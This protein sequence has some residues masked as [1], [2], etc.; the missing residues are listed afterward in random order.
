MCKANAWGKLT[1]VRPTKLYMDYVNR[2]GAADASELFMRD[3]AVSQAKTKQLAEIAQ[4]EK[5][6]IAEVGENSAAVYVNIPFC[7]SRCLYCSFVTCIKQTP[8]IMD[9]YVAAVMREIERRQ[10]PAAKI[11]SVYIGGG[12]PISIGAA[13]LSAIISALKQRY[14]IAP[15]VEFTVEAGRPDC[16]DGEILD[17]LQSHGVTRICINPQTLND[18]TLELIGRKHSAEDFFAA[19][20]MSRGRFRINCD[21]I[22]GLPNESMDDFTATLDGVLSCEPQGITVHTLCVKRGSRLNEYIGD[23]D[24]STGNTREMTDYAYRK[25]STSGYPPYYLYRQ[26]KT[27]GN[28]ENI[29]YSKPSHHCLYNIISIAESHSIYA[30]GAGAVTK[31]V[32]DNITREW[33]NKEPMAYIREQLT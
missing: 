10:F 7:P 12:T 30:Y 15:D 22:V 19:Y 1:G 13:R 29:G 14:E 33:N 4:Q 25:L 23:Y 28:L 26:K 21:I 16:I 5:Q 11:A 24:L 32:A 8:K 17:M 31:I 20:A 6:I 27:L 9:D 2:Y 18:S 3:Y